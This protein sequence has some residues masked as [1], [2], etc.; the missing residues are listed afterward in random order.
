[1]GQYFKP[2]AVPLILFLVPISLSMSDYQNKF[3]SG[4]LFGVAGFFGL[5]ALLSHKALL[6][7]FPWI[8]EFAPFSI[9]QVFT[10]QRIN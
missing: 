3:V 8:L 1:M 10:L 7:R 2:L 4:L 5:F 9:R 6:K